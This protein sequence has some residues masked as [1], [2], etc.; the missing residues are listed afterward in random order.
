MISWRPCFVQQLD[1]GFSQKSIRQGQSDEN[2]TEVFQRISSQMS[3]GWNGQYRRN[4]HNEGSIFTQVRAFFYKQCF[5]DEIYP[6]LPERLQF[7]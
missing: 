4:M 2:Q 3:S 1:F 5:H 6:F 7:S